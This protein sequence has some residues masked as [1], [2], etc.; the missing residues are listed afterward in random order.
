MAAL[1]PAPATGP[2]PNGFYRRTEEHVIATR[3][4]TTRRKAPARAKAA[5]KPVRTP[6]PDLSKGERTFVLD[7][8][9]EDRAAAGA[10]GAVW[11]PGLGWGWVGVRLPVAL[12]RYYP[13]P[14]SWQAWLAADLSG[15]GDGDSRPDLTTGSLTLRPDQEEDVATVLAARRAGCPEFLIGS[16][17]G[18]GKTAVAVSALKRMPGVRRILVVAPLSVL[19]NWRTHLEE[20]G[21]GGKRWCL[22]NY[23]STKKL[24]VP[25]RSAETAKRTRTKNLH[26]ARSGVGRVAWDVVVTD[27]SHYLGAPDSQRTL[28]LDRIAAGPGSKP[29]FL[30]RMS[31]T[32]GSNPAQLSYLHRGLFWRTGSTPLPT[33]TAERYQDW[34]GERG[35]G[36]T[37]GKFGTGLAWD[38]EPSGLT[39]MHH[40]LFSG[41]PSWAIRRVPDWP[42]QQRFLT[43]ID[44]D[45]DEMDAYDREWGEFASAMKDIERARRT[46]TPATRAKAASA[47]RVRGLAAQTRY[48]Q[49][50]G[51]LKAPHV[52]EFVADMVAKDRQVAVSC[53]YIGTVEALT[54]AL[55]KLR[56]RS[57]TFTGQN[58]DTREADRLSF[59]RGEV[60]VI[61]YTPAEGFNLHAGDTMVGGSATPRVTVV[62]EPRW[63]PKKALQCEGRT[64]R[65]A[66][67]A[68]CFYAY[69]TDT[70]ERDVLRTVISGMD[71]TAVINGDDTEPFSSL[72]SRVM[73]VPGVAA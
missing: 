24:L 3:R 13:K 33:I 62:A 14:Y 10:A 12:R 20:M 6:N 63:S 55:A 59:Q 40:L 56:V 60:P 50:A 57:V 22:I 36:I 58:R 66:N 11:Y 25:P 4:T 15:F 41:T 64:H 17:V 38:K 8:P 23:E 7:V 28:A 53:E 37:P 29:A 72:L 31:A 5:P 39:R 54:A 70:V 34:C 19:A 68:P 1:L 69:A 9:F 73:G 42:K 46:G 47:A 49:K 48:R 43:P 44:L 52:A 21:D 65:N 18:T 51:I 16:D 2:P 45:P 32:A 67:D 30:V 71:D 27:E 35:I 61:I 26:T